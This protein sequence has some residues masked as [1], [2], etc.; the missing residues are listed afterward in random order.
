MLIVV[1]V[2]PIARRH[3]AQSVT[4]SN[5]LFRIICVVHDPKTCPRL[6]AAIP[7]P[8]PMEWCFGS[9][10][11]KTAFAETAGAPRPIPSNTCPQT[12]SG[13]EHV[14]IKNA[15]GPISAHPIMY[16]YLYVLNL[17]HKTPN[18]NDEP[19]D[20]TIVRD[21]SIPD[22]DSFMSNLVC[23]IVGV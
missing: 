4:F 9:R 5:E 10:I 6:K 20:I 19:I 3:I 16:T 2:M 11:S 21:V 23:K 22:R 8:I 15:P 14:N 18:N 12:N 1:P 13:P 7:I 17:S